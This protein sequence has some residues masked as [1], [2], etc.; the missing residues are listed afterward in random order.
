MHKKEIKKDIQA[1]QK[2]VE[3]N[4]KDLKILDILHPEL[5][6]QQ[7][8]TQSQKCIQ[9]NV[10]LYTK[11]KA[12]SIS[13]DKG[14][15]RCIYSGN[16][17]HL[18]VT[19]QNGYASAFNT[20]SLQLCFETELDDKIYDAKWLH[21]EQYFATAQE[22]CVF[23]Y[24]RNGSE[25]HAVRDMRNTTL[26]DFLP[27]HFLLAGAS[28]NGF[29]NYLDTSTGEV[30]ST[31]FI[32]DR[33]SM[34]IKASPVNGVVH[35]G[36]KS[37]VVTLW[38]PSQKS[39]LMKVKCHRSAVSNIEIDRT[40]NYMITTGFDNKLSVFDLR[41]TYRPIRTINTKTSIHFTA[42]SERNLLAIGYSNKITIL[43]DVQDKETCV[44]K[45]T[46]PGIVS[47]LGFCN[48][49]DILTFGHSNGF[50]SIVVPGSGDPIYDTSETSPFMT[51]KERQALEVKRLLEKIPADMVSL[52][53]VFE[54]EKKPV[55]KP[56]EIK[57]YY[58]VE[59]RNALSRFE[60]K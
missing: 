25:L 11:E 47:S 17:S 36:T 22:D 13:M 26:L 37:G 24:D 23:V 27:Y 31:I 3:D 15:Y 60:K 1:F 40:G 29:L 30:V 9:N 53:S 39:Y 2:A 46:A 6:E 49:E 4:T 56:I 55:K 42:L 12:F 8:F 35:L 48:H 18:L 51:P 34:C 52:K 43:K 50:T 16:G 10:N 19:N 44:M 45:Y 7:S 28:K 5:P 32:G 58:E 57:R 59:T 14:P 21:N 41:N 20:Q 38:A 33:S 54:T